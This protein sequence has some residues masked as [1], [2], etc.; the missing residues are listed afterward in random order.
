M[1]TL[2]LLRPLSAGLFSPQRVAFDSSGNLWVLDSNNGRALEF[3]PPFSNGE[4]ASIVIGQ[5]NF[6]QICCLASPTAASLSNPSGMAFDPSGNL[7]ISDLGNARILEFK[8]PF[9]NSEN[10]S[11]VIG[12]PN[13]TASLDFTYNTTQFSVE[14]PTGLAFDHSGDLWAGDIGAER[15]LEFKPPFSDGMNA[16]LVLGQPNFTSAGSTASNVTQSSI[17]NPEGI[18]VD[19]SGNLW[20]AAQYEHR[21]LEFKPPFSNGE[22]ASLVLGQAG[23]FSAQ[24]PLKPNASSLDGPKDLT[25]DKSGNLWVSDT[26][27]NRVVEYLPPFKN[28]ENAS[29]AIG[30]FNLTSYAYNNESQIG[31]SSPT[32]LAFDSSGSL[33]V[34]DAL[35]DRVLEFQNLV[36]TSSATSTA[37]VQSNLADIN[38]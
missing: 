33:W 34:A 30:A 7:W 17:A 9:T 6:T 19:Q 28:D 10:A 13:F 11:L 14:A 22:N 4:N 32:G 1:Q 27:A 31:L 15:V 23:F 29:L 25:F 24:S 2:L 38:Y 12:Q 36:T 35:N 3:Q 21:I 5:F 8:P 20:I 16:S 18:A 37:A 26:Q